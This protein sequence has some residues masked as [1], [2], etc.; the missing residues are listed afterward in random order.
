MT[1]ILFVITKRIGDALSVTPSI[2]A[3]FF[4]YPNCEITVYCKKNN[5]DL[6]VS[7]KYIKKI[8]VLGSLKARLLSVIQFNKKFDKC[9]FYSENKSFLNLA[10]K[11]SKKIYAFES[12]YF[13]LSYS[14][15]YYIKRFEPNSRPHIIFEN[16]RLVEHANIQQHETHMD[17][18]LSSQDLSYQ[19][20]VF[21]EIRKRK[22]KIFCL[23]IMSDPGKKFRDWSLERFAELINLIFKYFS[24]SQILIVGSNL[25]E[26]YARKLEL[27][28]PKRIHIFCNQSLSK[29]AAIVFGADIYIGV[30]T[31]VT[32]I[33]SCSNK[34]VIGLYHCLIGKDKSGPLNN[35]LDYSIE[36]PIPKDGCKRINGS[37]D[38][39][40]AQDV[41]KKIQEAFR[42]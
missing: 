8:K 26:V 18:F 31:G 2:R 12:P 13:N 41:L 37:L 29:T 6:F 33:A 27:I 30:D 3:V 17:L 9:F 38:L 16:L 15:I 42:Q 23:K 40:S 11:N 10:E 20:K 4:H 22:E 32:Q 34:P 28:N 21:Q 24:H 19:K 1:K 36:M 5:K 35:E 39:I 7:N 25:E 14:Q